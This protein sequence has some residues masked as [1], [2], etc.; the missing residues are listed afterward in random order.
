MVTVSAI[1]PDITIGY[2]SPAVV[3]PEITIT[4]IEGVEADQ[5]K[6]FID[7]YKLEVSCDEYTQYLASGKTIGNISDLSKAKL[8]YQTNTEYVFN[9]DFNKSTVTPGKLS[10]KQNQYKNIDTLKKAEAFLALGEKGE[11]ESLEKITDE[12]NVIK[13]SYCWTVI[14]IARYDKLKEDSEIFSQNT[15]YCGQM[16]LLPVLMLGF[17]LHDFLDSTGFVPSSSS[18]LSLLVSFYL[19]AFTLFS[20]CTIL[21]CLYPLNSTVTLKYLTYS[22]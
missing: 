6:D 5:L 9:I 13:D 4:G 17:L 1:Y 15:A 10:V 7:K 11:K 22:F 3:K 14:N 19:P 2:Y 16:L 12:T 21:L 8:T 20:K 18:C